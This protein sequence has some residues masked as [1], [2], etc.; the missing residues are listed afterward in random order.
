ML[1]T[2]S[3]QYRSYSNLAKEYAGKSPSQ[4]LEAKELFPYY[5]HLLLRESYR[6]A[7]THARF[8]Y[9]E[10][11]SLTAEE[12]YAAICEFDKATY[13]LNELGAYARCRIRFRVPRR[14]ARRYATSLFE[15]RSNDDA[16]A[17]VNLAEDMATD[18]TP[19][20]TRRSH[21]V[22]AVAF[23]RR[24][25]TPRNQARL[26]AWLDVEAKTKQ[27]LLSKRAQRERHEKKSQRLRRLGSLEWVALLTNVNE[28]LDTFPEHKQQ[29]MEWLDES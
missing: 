13:S 4:D 8:S 15:K 5:A 20:L 14:L 25:L 10:I 22:E 16:F 6:L 18:S 9:D 27:V 29:L 23:I 7:F 19:E 11:L 12:L 3:L 2:T 26:D 28:V 21:L 1:D 24:Y 17:A